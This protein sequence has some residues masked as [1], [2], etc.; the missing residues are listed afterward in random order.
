MLHRWLL[1]VRTSLCSTYKPCPYGSSVLQRFKHGNM[2]EICNGLLFDFYPRLPHTGF[3]SPAI[4]CSNVRAPVAQTVRASDQNSGDPGLSPGR[5]SWTQPS[6]SL[7]QL[8]PFKQPVL[9][10][11]LPPFKN[12][13]HFVLPGRP[14]SQYHPSSLGGGECC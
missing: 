10:F 14:W 4:H 5:T 13:C 11:V 1:D 8:S 6:G 12:W 3:Q 9:A 7:F 2:T